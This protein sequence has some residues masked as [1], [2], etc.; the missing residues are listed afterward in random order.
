MSSN[1]KDPPKNSSRPLSCQSSSS[2]TSESVKRGAQLFQE[3][4][5]KQQNNATKNKNKLK[6]QIMND[7]IGNKMKKDA[8]KSQEN[9][10][11]H[12]EQRPKNDF[13]K[14]IKGKSYK[15]R[16]DKE[17]KELKPKQA[18]LKKYVYDTKISRN[19]RSGYK[20]RNFHRLGSTGYRK[21][22]DR[23]HSVE[24]SDEEEGRGVITSK[25]ANKQ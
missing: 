16:S 11:K 20:F 12:V 8:T 10:H 25:Q 19:S 6:K 2:S 15:S 18:F 3:R 13:D 1:I 7:S 24:D 22:S 17:L 9:I 5:R 14:Q 4:F 23:I 21:R